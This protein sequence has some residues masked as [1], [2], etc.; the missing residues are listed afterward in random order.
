MF[1]KIALLLPDIDASRLKGNF[2]E[3]YGDTF[4]NYYIRDP[5]YLNEILLTKLKFNVKPHWTLYTEITELGTG[6]HIDHNTV[7][8]NYYITP[9]NCVTIFWK[10]KLKNSGQIVN[11]LI[12]NGELLQNTV[13]KYDLKDL[14]P[15][16]S[17]KAAA[18]E[19]YLLDIKQ[20]HSA[21]RFKDC[22]IRSM[23]RWSWDNVTFDEIANSITLLP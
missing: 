6:A 9:A 5:A 3:G 8:L 18:D 15:I 14:T 12:N 10:E 2:C 17:F 4:K 19:A 13:R 7:A 11:Q 20:I 22:G 23:I 16:A 21:T 1:K